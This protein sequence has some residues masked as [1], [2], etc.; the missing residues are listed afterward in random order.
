MEQ[1]IAKA[2]LGNGK[3]A[4]KNGIRNGVNGNGF[5]NGVPKGVKLKP[6]LEDLHSGDLAKKQAAEQ[7]QKQISD[8]A[9]RLRDTP[10]VFDVDKVSDRY[11]QFL[12]KPRQQLDDKIYPREAAREYSKAGQEYYKQ[13]QSLAGYP[14]YKDPV[15]GEAT[16]FLRS[17]S[18]FNKDGSLRVKSRKLGNKAIEDAKRTRWEEEQTLGPSGRDELV[19]HKTPLGLLDRIAA[20]LTP[21]Q[22]RRFYE[23][24]H[25]NDRWSSLKVGNET[26]NLVGKVGDRSF[27]PVHVDVHDLIKMAGLDDARIDF[28]GATMEQRYGFLDEIT[29]LL[30][31]IDEFI[32][33][34]RMASKFPKMRTESGE[35]MFKGYKRTPKKKKKKKGTT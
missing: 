15:T 33:A 22:R 23:Y 6:K 16:H 14:P 26:E 2:I 18:E 31:Q 9:Q 12:N 7:W 11:S 13:H 4:V 8:N 20:G 10:Q 28:T 21:A 1:A 34:Q 30:D 25:N 19:H 3:R 29:P 35:K 24:V 32:Y 5:K 27:H 17:N